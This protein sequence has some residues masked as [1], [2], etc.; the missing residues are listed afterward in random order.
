MTVIGEHVTPMGTSAPTP[1]RPRRNDPV[2]E[3]AYINK[4]REY[5]A[6]SAQQKTYGD[7]ALAALDIGASDD[8]SR[9]GDRKKRE[10]EQSSSGELHV[11][12]WVC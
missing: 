5:Y 2:S 11:E 9:C 12:S 10:G 1:S 6:V 8:R 3:F 4:S 7:G